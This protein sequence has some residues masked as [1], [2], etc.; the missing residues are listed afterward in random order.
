MSGV[1]SSDREK[2]KIWTAILANAKKPDDVGLE[3]KA[4]KLA[5]EALTRNP[6][7]VQLWMLRAQAEPSET[8]TIAFYDRALDIAPQDS[9][10][11]HLRMHALED[12]G[13]LSTAVSDGALLVKLAGAIPHAHHMYGHELRR[14]GRTQE[15]IAEFKRAEELE[16]AYYQ[17]QNI[18]AEYDWHHMHNLNLLASAYLH[19]GGL[20]RAEQTLKESIATP[21][22]TVQYAVFK[23]DWPELLLLRGRSGE[24]L[25]AAQEMMREKWPQPQMIGH[26]LAGEAL[27]VMGDRTQAEAELQAAQKVVTDNKQLTQGVEYH[28]KTL[29]AELLPGTSETE[30]GVADLE[31]LESH[32]REAKSPDQ[33][34]QNLFHL[35][36]IA[37]LARQY[38]AWDLAKH[39]AEQMI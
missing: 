31:E 32:F 30:A 11:L 7:D 14:A 38:N 37:R 22:L 12:I 23:E 10:A 29:A 25:R 36:R 26:A 19:E 18:P 6:R 2:I 8:A 17:S 39:T 27:L 4:I 24:A 15:A 1:S 34:N 3:D 28:A 33:W 20:E 9:G 21:S 13:Q 5:D 35:E 16:L